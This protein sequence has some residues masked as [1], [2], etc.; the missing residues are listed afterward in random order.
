[1]KQDRQ[2][3]SNKGRE[4]HKT[5]RLSLRLSGG[6]GDIRGETLGLL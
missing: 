6:A 4:G 5:G 3:H 2:R 1:M